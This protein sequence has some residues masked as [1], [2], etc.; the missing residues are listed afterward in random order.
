MGYEVDFL[1]AGNGEKSGDAIAVRFGDLHSR[2]RRDHEP[3]RLAIGS[4][5]LHSRPTI[6]LRARGH[7]DRFDTLHG[8][9]GGSWVLIRP[10]LPSS[11]SVNSARRVPSG[12]DV[13]L[14]LFAT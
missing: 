14:F 5:P 7:R 11:V 6:H 9:G 1:P 4:D 13:S 2:N 12:L 8:A 10:L 3:H